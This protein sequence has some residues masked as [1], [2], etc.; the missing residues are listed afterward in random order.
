METRCSRRS[1]KRLRG[2][3]SLVTGRFANFSATALCEELGGSRDDD[4]RLFAGSVP[5][6]DGG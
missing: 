3:G 6:A 5:F 4:P 1:A 2:A